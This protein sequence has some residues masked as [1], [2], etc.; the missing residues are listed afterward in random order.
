M[1]EKQYNDCTPM[2]LNNFCLCILFV[3]IIITSL[4]TIMLMHDRRIDS[5]KENAAFCGHVMANLIELPHI[6]YIER[7]KRRFSFNHV[8][9]TSGDGHSCQR[10]DLETAQ[11]KGINSAMRRN[12]GASGV[13]HNIHIKE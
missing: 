7:A 9:N 10:G 13:P 3:F 6:D 12:G 5:T 4:C 8:E 1:Y 11:M 2:Y